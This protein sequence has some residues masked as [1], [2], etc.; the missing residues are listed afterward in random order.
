MYFSLG[1]AGR[2]RM[3]RLSFEETGV[4][5]S[6]MLDDLGKG[7]ARTGEA[8]LQDVALDAESVDKL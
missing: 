2:R 6:S 8:K 7:E 1:Q 4:I 3:A 5:E